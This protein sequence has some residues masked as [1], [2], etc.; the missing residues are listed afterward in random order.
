MSKIG[1]RIRVHEARMELE[2]AERAL[3][4]R[5]R[6]WRRYLRHHYTSLLIGS[7]LVGGF[8]LA[9]VAPKQWAR[10]GAIFFSSGARL[11]QSALLPALLG[12]LWTHTRTGADATEK[13]T[14]NSSDGA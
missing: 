4:S 6:P 11:A 7:G 5:C 8:A 3:E 13:P 12:A 2:A 10:L 1:A 14:G 9:A